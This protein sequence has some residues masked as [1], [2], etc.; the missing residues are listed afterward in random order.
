M[1]ICSFFLLALLLAAVLMA[2]MATYLLGGSA[3]SAVCGWFRDLGL[4]RG[5]LRY[6]SLVPY[7]GRRTRPRW[8]KPVALVL[9]LLPWLIALSQIEGMFQARTCSEVLDG[10]YSP[11]LLETP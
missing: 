10:Q 3:L 1:S 9:A 2:S 5:K 4:R 6:A 8:V 7:R 11:I